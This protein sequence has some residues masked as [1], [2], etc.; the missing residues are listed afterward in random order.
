M[1]QSVGVEEEEEDQ[2]QQ[3]AKRPFELLRQGTH[4]LL[5][6]IFLVVQV[7]QPTSESILMARI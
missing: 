6:Q 1:L 3:C 7:P 4:S 2:E 5:D